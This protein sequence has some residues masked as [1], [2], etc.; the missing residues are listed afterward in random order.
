MARISR[1]LAVCTFLLVSSSNAA[2][3]GLIVASGDST[4][5]ATAGTPDN[6]VFFSNVLGVGTSVVVHEAPNDFLG[7]SLS[8][9]YGS[10]TG[11]SSAY[12]NI[13]EITASML[14]GV[15]L[16]VSSLFG[17]ALSAGEVSL[18]NTFVDGGGSLMFMGEY[19]NT[20]AGINSALAELGSAMRLIGEPDEPAGSY[21]AIVLSD[22]LTSGVSSFTYGYGYGVSGGTSIFK[23]SISNRVFMAY[24]N[25]NGVSEPG[26]FALLGLGL[27]AL[28]AARRR[29]Q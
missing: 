13:G 10:L 28:A 11:V 15:D 26:A 25:V 14:S 9:F 2:A 24:E 18:L 4:P 12:V 8:N 27:A 16:F 7:T 3:V 6:N 29:K 20:F 21:S 1:V 17:G 23:E 5:M 22:P 19:T